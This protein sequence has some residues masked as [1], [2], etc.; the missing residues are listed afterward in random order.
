MNVRISSMPSRAG[1]I[2]CAVILKGDF[3]LNQNGKSNPKSGKENGNPFP[4]P[5]C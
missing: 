2:L 5:Y 1:D 3:G 4:N